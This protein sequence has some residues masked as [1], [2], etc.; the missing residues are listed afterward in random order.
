MGF[1]CVQD[2][3]RHGVEMRPIDVGVADWDAQGRTA[4]LG[5][6]RTVSRDFC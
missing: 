4:L 1:Y 5:R 2:A 6:L 3:R